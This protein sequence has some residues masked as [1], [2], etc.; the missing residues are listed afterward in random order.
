[1]GPSEPRHQCC[2]DLD[3]QPEVLDPEIFVGRVLV[4]VV[5]GDRHDDDRW[6]TEDLREDEERQAATETR[7][8][9][10]WPLDG[11]VDNPRHRL[12]DRQ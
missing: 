12:G 2:V 11:F 9:H 8:Q 6:R 3:P 10:D 1:M 5:V 4:V 7:S